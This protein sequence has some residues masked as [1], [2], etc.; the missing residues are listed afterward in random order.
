[1]KIRHLAAGLGILASITACAAQ[2]SPEP[3]VPAASPAVAAEE[4]APTNGSPAAAPGPAPAREGLD[5]RKSDPARDE[6][7]FPNLEAAERALDQAKTD[8]DR[9]ALAQP[10]PAFR[11]DA[12][13]EKR[14]SEPGRARNAAGAATRSN[15][16][17]VCE[18]ACRAFSSLT[19]AANAVCRLDGRTG[20]HCSRAKQVQADA[21]QR[22]ASCSCPPASD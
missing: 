19:R 17:P 12:P 2:R 3:S 16:T 1:M 11:R 20:T 7:E 8:L 18:E 21:Q 4:R 9:V 6:P 22:V 10:S 13:T 15:T 14:E 5:A